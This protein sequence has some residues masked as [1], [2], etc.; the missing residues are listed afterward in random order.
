MIFPFYMDN[1]DVM[2]FQC[3]Q[4]S[5]RFSYMYS[6]FSVHSSSNICAF[7]RCETVLNSPSFKK[8]RLCKKLSI[9]YTDHQELYHLMFN[10]VL[11][12]IIP[13]YS[14]THRCIK[15]LSV[16]S[17][18]IITHTNINNYQFLLYRQQ[19]NC[20]FLKKKLTFCFLARDIL[21]MLGA[22]PTLERH[23]DGRKNTMQG[24]FTHSPL[25]FG[26]CLQSDFFQHKYASFSCIPFSTLYVW[27]Y[28]SP[29][30]S[31]TPLSFPPNDRE[32][33]QQ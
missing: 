8:R 1:F 14:P 30:F 3:K 19:W 24:P 9:Y 5:P 13:S 11:R 17:I 15:V 28:P 33:V 32:R 10:T 22:S 29:L 7:G 6:F 27:F 31:V 12:D 16:L 2:I 4:G 21:W 20:L 25:A 18:I 26:T 23:L